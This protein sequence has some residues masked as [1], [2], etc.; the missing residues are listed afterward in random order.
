[1]STKTGINVGFVLLLVFTVMSGCDVPVKKKIRPDDSDYLTRGKLLFEERFD[2]PTLTPSW[3]GGNAWVVK[4]GW[5]TVK[6]NEN[7]AMWLEQELP[8]QARVEFDARA[9]SEEGDIKCE[10][11][12]DGQTH[13][14]GYIVI[15]GGWNNTENKIAR[16]DEH[17][18]NPA[19][20]PNKT[21]EKNKT[22]HFTVLRVENR[23]SWFIDKQ[24]MAVYDDPHPLT[25]PSHTYFAFNAWRAPISFDNLEI[26]DLT[27]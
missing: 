10:V 8:E 3:R 21:V 12:A 22:Y 2:K 7:S 19:R 20:G 5:L 9:G 4:D 16:L 23:I 15:F 13:A 14:S 24:L 27:E 1:M 26:Y 25:G 6:M 17:E 11:F 18:K